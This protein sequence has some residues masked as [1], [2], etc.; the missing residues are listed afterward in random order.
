MCLT[1]VCLL[2]SKL[3]N[4]WNH[5]YLVLPSLHPSSQSG[6]LLGPNLKFAQGKNFISG[7]GCSTEHKFQK[8]KKSPGPWQGPEGGRAGELRTLC[9]TLPREDV[10]G[11]DLDAG[12]PQ[13]S[14]L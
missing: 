4:G 10:S 2:E 5:I 3:V 8:K 9:P 1:D 6:T 14:L 11:S 13:R 12:S 7:V